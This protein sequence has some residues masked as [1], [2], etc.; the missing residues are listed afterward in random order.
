M[1]P[2]FNRYYSTIIFLS[3]IWILIISI[4]VINPN[5]EIKHIY[6]DLH[7]LF[8]YKSN[9]KKDQLYEFFNT[10]RFVLSDFFYTYSHTHQTI[11][12]I[13]QIRKTRKQNCV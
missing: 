6:I 4:K 5:A 10:R 1:K 2:A 13:M 7:L 8:E 9:S 3:H 11:E 12:K